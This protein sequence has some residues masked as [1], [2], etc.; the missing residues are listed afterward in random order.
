[1]DV[2]AEIM[3]GNLTFVWFEL[4]VIVWVTFLGQ[5]GASLMVTE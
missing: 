2:S 1:L 5:G 4:I 3:A